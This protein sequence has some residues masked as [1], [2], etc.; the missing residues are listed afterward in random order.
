R[1]PD[2][3]VR[4]AAARALGR[5]RA[6]ASAPALEELAADAAAPGEAA[7]AA[8]H[9]L[10][11]LGLARPEVLARAA[12]HPD[13]EVVKEAVLAAVAV[14]GAAASA[15]L[16]AAAAHARWDVRSAAARAMGE[17]GDRALADPLRRLA[18]IE[19]DP[20]VVEALQAALRRL[21]AQAQ[22]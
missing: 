19:G 13:A 17:R 10:S 2:A 5:A 6:A 14:P 22:R 16:L 8:L 4:A 7:A 15:L 9:A 1:D 20:L 11:E 21:E 18:A 3:A 12:R